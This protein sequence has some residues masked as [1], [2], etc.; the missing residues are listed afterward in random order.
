[1]LTLAR[2]CLVFYDLPPTLDDTYTGILTRVNRHHHREALALL[3]WLAYARSPPT[4]GELVDAAITDPKEEDG[5]DAGECGG[6]RDVLNILSGLVMIEESKGNA[7]E[8]P[9]KVRPLV[10]SISTPALGQDVTMFYSQHFTA[11]TRARL[12]QFS[13]K[14]YLESERILGTKTDQFHLESAI[15]HQTL[16]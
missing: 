6:L 7:A 14:E 15:G 3:R 12:A 16:A 10:S 9:F 5:I 13:V 8:T 4:L 11:D 1:M 2:L